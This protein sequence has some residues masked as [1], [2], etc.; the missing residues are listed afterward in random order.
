MVPLSLKS[1]YDDGDTGHAGAA[2]ATV[3]V[4]GTV[5]LGVTMLADYPQF[6]SKSVDTSLRSGL[7]SVFAR[8]MAH[9]FLPTGGKSV[10]KQG[11]EPADGQSQW[12]CGDHIAHVMELQGDHGHADCA[13]YSENDSYEQM[14]K[15]GP[16]ETRPN[17][18]SAPAA[19]MITPA[20][21]TDTAV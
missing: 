21:A 1:R 4:V 8:E 16:H 6:G 18:R 5:L 3:V 15:R 11:R 19:M 2:I 13:G 12:Y 10:Q 14:A 17:G 7:R 20:K 9:R